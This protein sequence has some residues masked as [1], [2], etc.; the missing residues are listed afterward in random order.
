MKTKL[1]VSGGYYGDM[2]RTGPGRIYQTKTGNWT[3]PYEVNTLY[4]DSTGTT[5]VTAV[6]QGIGYAADTS[7]SGN[8]LIQ[9]TGASAPVWRKRYNLL[10][11]SEQFDNA[12][13]TKSGLLAFGSGSIAN[14]TTAPDGTVTADLIVENTTTGQHTAYQAFSTGA[15]APFSGVVWLKYAGKQYISV[16]VD[17]GSAPYAVVDLLS[18]VVVGGSGV[19]VT[20][21]LS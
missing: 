3:E 1:L 16:R 20:A 21:A 15:A 10:T 4:Q 18:G 13:W 12:S 6:E 17:N 19:T 11:Y 14:A 7:G 2:V 8:H 9:A 5:P